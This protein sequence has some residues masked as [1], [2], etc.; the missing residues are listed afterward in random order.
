MQAPLDVLTYGEAMAMF[1][2]A[3]PGPLDSATQFTKRI[4][5]ADLNVAIGLARLG[6]RVGW[7]SRVGADS[8]GRYV[9][10]T[11]ARERVDASCVTIDARYPTGF[12]LKSRATDGADPAVEYFRKGSAASRLSLDDYAPGYALG[13]RHLHLTGVAPALS[14]S[15][16][17]LAFHLA[18]TMRAAGK[19]VSFDPNL[20]PTLWPSAHE[21]AR[22]LNAL[23]EQ[24]D[25][26]LPGLAEGRQLTG[27]DTPADIAGFYIERGARGVVVKLG[28]AGAYFRTDDG[29]EGTVAA[30]R[31]E[32]VVDT[33][34]AGDGFAVGV[35]SALLEG[36]AIDDAVARGNRIGALAIQVI[37]D[38]EGLPLRAQ[39]DRIEN[40]SN[41]PDR[42]EAPLVR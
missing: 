5:G 28:A 37:G 20:R 25:W 32:H 33:V 3:E 2:A 41:A 29:R 22:T 10:D 36:R 15:S 39:L 23:A 17:E 13:A 8:F 4:A 7:I 38:S 26:V 34:G 35:V 12:Q 30:E 14:D 16:R 27:L 40:L 9:L 31:V 18:R 6:F 21:M 1:V 11:L 24:A 19:T 42:L